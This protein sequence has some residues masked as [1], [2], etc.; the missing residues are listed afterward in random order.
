MVRKR[1]DQELDLAI[2]E[3]LQ[4]ALLARAEFVEQVPLLAVRE[5]AH[6]V[7]L[8]NRRDLLLRRLLRLRAAAAGGG[9]TAATAASTVAVALVVGVVGGLGVRG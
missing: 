4:L 5:L 8:H 3:R 2:R 7:R 9:A 6:V 1:A